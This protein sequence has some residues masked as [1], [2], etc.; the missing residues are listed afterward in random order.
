MVV[1]GIGYTY[2][3]SFPLWHLAVFAERAWATIRPAEFEKSGCVYAVIAA[4]IVVR[5]LASE[6]GSH[7]LSGLHAMSLATDYNANTQTQNTR[8]T[9]A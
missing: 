2:S 6:Q 7:S 8:D 4:G 9:E 1:R 5:R 3:I